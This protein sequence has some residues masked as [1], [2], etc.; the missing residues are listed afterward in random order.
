MK[1]MY[2]VRIAYKKSPTANIETYR[3]IYP[4]TIKGFQDCLSNAINTCEDDETVM[5]IVIISAETP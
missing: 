4:A 2:E 1:A 5:S 3:W